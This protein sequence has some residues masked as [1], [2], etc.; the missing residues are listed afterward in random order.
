MR[1]MMVVNAI[2]V[3]CVLCVC[4]V[5]VYIIQDLVDCVNRNP[6]N[7]IVIIIID[8]VFSVALSTRITSSSALKIDKIILSQLARRKLEN[9]K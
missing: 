1:M 8:V 6:L 9:Q 5:F 7:S 3:Y 4:I 2:A